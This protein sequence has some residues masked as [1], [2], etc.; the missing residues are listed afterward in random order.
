HQAGDQEDDHADYTEIAAGVQ[1]EDARHEARGE[2]LVLVTLRLRHLAFLVDRERVEGAFVARLCVE[3]AKLQRAVRS[4]GQ[5][6]VD[7]CESWH[8]AGEGL[9]RAGEVRNIRFAS[10]FARSAFTAGRSLDAS[11][12]VETV[13]VPLVRPMQSCQLDDE[14]DR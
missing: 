6:D 12:A 1:R 8:L 5:I 4:G 9:P 2:S 14:I 13:S 10:C 7:R 11:N 3:V